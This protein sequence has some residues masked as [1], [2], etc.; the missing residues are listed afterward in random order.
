MKRLPEKLLFYGTALVVCLMLDQHAAAQKTPRVRI[1]INDAWK[2]FPGEAAGAERSDINDAGWQDV[3]IPHTWNA[4]DTVDDEPGYRRGAGWYRR[5]LKFDAS[6]RGKRIFVFFEGANQIADV[7]VNGTLAGRHVGGYTAFCFDVTDLLR[8][9]GRNLLAVRIDNS[10]V[11]DIPPIDGD[12]NMYGGIYRDA[13]ILATDSVHVKTTDAASSGIVIRTPRVSAETATVEIAGTIVNHSAKTRDVEIVNR[14]VG[15]DRR[16]AATL[17]SKVLLEPNA[18]T[19]FKQTSKPIR[20]PALWSPDNPDLYTVTTTVREDRRVLDEV[21]NPLGF[22]WFRFDPENGFFL[23]GRQL[24]LRGTNRHQDH[25]G[26]GN[27]TPD[28]LHV[29]DL[30]TIKNDGFNFLRLAHYPQDPSVLEA[31]DRLGI[32]IWEE[33]PIVN[34]IHVSAKFNENAKSMLREMIRQHRNH[35]SIIIWGYM[36]EVFLPVPKDHEVVRATVDLARE[37]ETICRTQDPTRATAIAFD[38]GAR[39]LYNT[40]GLGD[41]PQVVGWNLYHGW[42]YETF[43]DLGKFLDDQHRRFP[44]RSIIVSEYGANGDR[45]VHAIAP[46]RFDSSIEWQ[47]KFHEAYLPQLEGRSFIAGSAIWN[48]FDFGSEFRGETIP[49]INQKG[50]YTFDRQPKDVSFFY[51]ASYSNEPVLHI[52]TRDWS[53]RSGPRSQ[54]IV[55]Y[56]NAAR[57]EL[58]HNGASLGT[59]SVQKNKV[60]WPVNFVDGRNLLLAVT[61]SG[62][63]RVSDQAEV[64]FDQRATA[65]SIGVNSGSHTEVVDDAGMI[66]QA[67]ATV[68][69]R[70]WSLVEKDSKP[71]ETRRNILGTPDDPVYQT[72]REGE[73]EYHFDV[74]D[75]PYEIELR[76][77]ETKFMGSGERVFS[78]TANER[79]VLDRI[80]LIKEAGFFKYLSRTVTANASGGAGLR[81]NLIAVKNLPIIS[82]IRVKRIDR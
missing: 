28:R 27:A 34:Q 75:G 77:V 19:S 67:E 62:A 33:I 15:P 2:F 69:T 21:S 4:E 64:H 65:G 42:Y 46:R 8:I 70:G 18:E 81:I 52:A 11:K 9:G 82:G 43:D 14:L 45:R 30:E 49:H 56:S 25:A 60:S 71:V 47:Q 10:H 12:F 72:M 24:K 41:V 40:S 74:P 51:R 80:D 16:S 78:V 37:L 35:P 53:R 79:R 68:E 55:V 38:W 57:V 66:W 39:D 50:M 44:N 7:F 3:K 61:G 32:L 76:F 23:N 6:F 36:N 20:K 59:R 5:E 13:W 22:R 17:V 29:A 1:S 73:A 63:R 54:S 58:F 48:Q 31:A 26:L